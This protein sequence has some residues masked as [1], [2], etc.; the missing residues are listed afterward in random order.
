[1]R[2]GRG[3][4]VPSRGMTIHRDRR[5]PQKQG[6]SDMVAAITVVQIVVCIVALVAVF[7]LQY[8][9]VEK[10]ERAGDYYLAVMG[11]GIENEDENEADGEAVYVGAF[12]EPIDGELLKKGADIIKEK[13]DNV[14]FAQYLALGAGGENPY[15]PTNVYLGELAISAQPIYPTF[16]VVTSAFGTR[17]HPISDKFD[18]HTG[19]D[20][21]APMKSDIYTVW[22]GTVKEVG[23]N[24]T[25][26]N[27]IKISHG[28][29]LETVYNHCSEILAKEGAVVRQG[30]RVALVGSTG[31]ST[32]SHLHFTV[33]VN[34][35]YI[36]PLRLYKLS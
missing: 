20:I 6:I 13:I 16:G 32:G 27:Y 17:E 12:A 22:N 4:S 19:I 25:Y 24:A 33:L 3:R 15:I 26:G 11:T 35:N 28:K 30:E 34:G 29:S 1:M 5:S 10:F 31:V 7:T 14:D 23:Y 21:A 8:I 2:G 36:N 18:F 9:S